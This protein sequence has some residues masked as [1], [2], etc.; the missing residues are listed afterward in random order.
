[1]LIHTP[2]TTYTYKSLC[3][4]DRMCFILKAQMCRR[5]KTK[6]DECC[7]LEERENRKYFVLCL[8]NKFIL[9]LS[10][11]RKSPNL[12]ISPRYRYFCNI[13]IAHHPVT[14]IDP[15]MK[16]EIHVI[17]YRIQQK[18]RTSNSVA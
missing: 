5:K 2:Y 15:R 8:Q 4:D 6:S 17:S 13:I 14:M 9:V 11:E 18:K 7:E 10:K 16:Y 1:M 12:P 3:T